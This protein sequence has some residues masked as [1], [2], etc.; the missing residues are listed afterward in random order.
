MFLS[1][2]LC[3]GFDE[4][5][6]ELGTPCVGHCFALK[7]EQLAKMIREKEQKVRK[8]FCKTFKALRN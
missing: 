2:F 8:L 6:A 3:K 4:D 1:I 5:A 7:L